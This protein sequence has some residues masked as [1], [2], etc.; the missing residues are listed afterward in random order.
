[1]STWDEEHQQSAIRLLAVWALLE[2]SEQALS[3]S[4]RTPEDSAQA[5]G[6]QPA[7]WPPAPAPCPDD[8]EQTEAKGELVLL[9]ARECDHKAT[10]QETRRIAEL[11]EYLDRDEEALRWWQWAAER[12]DE[13]ARDYLDLLHTE[14]QEQESSPVESPTLS[15]LENSAALYVWKA[16]GTDSGSHTFAAVQLALSAAANPELSEDAKRLVRQ[17]EE[18][19]QHPDRMTDGRRR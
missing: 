3:K 19:L 12:G 7:S 4:P 16:S 11:L 17:I 15:E 6:G 5:E 10:A 8:R 14:R 18:Y 13:D 1:M 9:L 2:R